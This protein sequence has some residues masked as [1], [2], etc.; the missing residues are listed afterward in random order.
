MTYL[1]N[2]D[3]Q[4]KIAG[5][6]SISGAFDRQKQE[7]NRQLLIEY[8]LEKWVNEGEIGSYEAMKTGYHCGNASDIAKCREDSVKTVDQVQAKLEEVAD[9]NQFKLTPA[10]AGRLLGYTFFSQSNP[11]QSGINEGQ[12]GKYF[13]EEFDRQLLSEQAENIKI[14]VLL[15]NGRYDTNVPF[16]EAEAVYDKLGTPPEKKA[17]AILEKSGHL[18]MITEPE[19]L[20][21]MIIR[22]VEVP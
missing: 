7:Q 6:I 22:F 21:E 14:P 2:N 1:K 20:S 13:Q 19:A 17:I 12:N 15:I 16:F 10:A 9:Y 11:L 18:P 5:F 3:H 8:L 4:Q